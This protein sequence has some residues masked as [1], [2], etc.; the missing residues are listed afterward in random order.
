M[1]EGSLDT[2]SGQ[3]EGQGKNL[4]Q[5]PLHLWHPD[6]SGDI[7]IV[8]RRDGSWVHEGRPIERESLLRLFASILR[9]E[10]DDEYYLVTP[11]EKW[12]LRVECLP[13][14]VVNFE[15]E[16]EEGGEQ[17]LRVLLNTGREY[18]IDREHPL[19]LPKLEGVED[20]AAVRLDNGL[21]ALFSRSAWYRLVDIIEE[22]DGVPG[23]FSA[24]CF[25]PLA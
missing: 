23:V 1:S 7:D 18:L 2:L 5:P 10:D 25:F 19:F 13:L 20:I 16:G 3:I 4:Q 6:V 11:V 24:G 21:A 15:S 12:R 9:R 8:I 17:K 14:L 22:R